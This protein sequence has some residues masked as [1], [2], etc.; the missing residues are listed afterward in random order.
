MI[1]EI[2]EFAQLLPQNIVG[3][4]VVVVIMA[5]IGRKIYLEISKDKDGLLS[6]YEARLAH[7]EAKIDSMHE[8][9]LID[10]KALTVAQV[11]LAT[12]RGE[13]QNA[14]EN[15][16]RCDARMVQLEQKYEKRIQQ[17]EEEIVILRVRL[18]DDAETGFD[19]VI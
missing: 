10:S 2:T 9:H 11:E 17:L 8:A 3:Y 12:I 19:D 7:V 16:D 6:R 13:L 5:Y 14:K 4:V 18:S 15:E 1:K